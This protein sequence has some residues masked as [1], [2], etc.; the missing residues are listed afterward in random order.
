MSIRWKNFWRILGVAAGA[1]ALVCLWNWLPPVPAGTGT[2]AA[3][4]KTT[5]ST[6]ATPSASLGWWDAMPQSLQWIFIGV[7]GLLLLFGVVALLKYT[8]RG[9]GGSGTFKAG[10]FSSQVL[11]GL[12][13]T[14]LLFAVLYPLNPTAPLW[15][16]DEG[17]FH[18]LMY[19]LAIIVSVMIATNLKS[20]GK[21]SALVILFVVFAL[22][23]PRTLMLYD[24]NGVVW[25]KLHLPSGSS[26]RH[27]STTPSCP[28]GY[29]PYP[30][31]TRSLQKVS[32]YDCQ[33]RV[34][35]PLYG[36]CATTYDKYQRP[37]GRSCPTGQN[38]VNGVTY[39]LMADSGPTEAKITLCPLGSP[40]Q[41]M[42]SCN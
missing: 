21:F 34:Q 6:P 28:G 27:T 30:L 26:S 7:A 5:V 17:H 20:F 16:T 42:G 23:G 29:E 22:L 9:V 11:T 39:Y 4:N 8:F 19:G 40:G 14:G 1:I 3:T 10:S 24:P 38:V 32:G 37:I 36:G 33:V 18:L 13:V 35:L 2:T 15:S 41:N 12:A 25:A 31:S